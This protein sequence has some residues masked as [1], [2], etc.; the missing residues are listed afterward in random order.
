MWRMKAYLFDLDGTL[1]DSG[2][3]LYHSFRAALKTLELP[4]LDDKQLAPFLG[5]PLPEMF[6]ALRPDISLPEIEL[7]I[8]GFRAAYESAG[9]KQTTLYPGV[10][11]M[12]GA[13]VDR[14]RS[15]WIVTSK[16][17]HYAAIVAKDLKLDRY[18]SGIT[19]AGL[20]ERDTKRELIARALAALKVSER[21]AIM[22]GDRH[23]DVIGARANNVMPV[24]VLWGYGSYQELFDA[25]C[26]AFA[27]SVGEFRARFV[28]ADAKL[29]FAAA[30]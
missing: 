10:I 18:I 2:P 26:R 4:S 6:R 21:D 27:R 24:G 19:G 29:P 25:G 11:E 1:A 15:I 12:L 13:I 17:E 9:I 3:G 8:K 20:D 7:G 5:T 23:Y 22:V 30:E 14:D 28:E 16:P